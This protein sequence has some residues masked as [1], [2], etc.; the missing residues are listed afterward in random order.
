[1]KV[2]ALFLIMTS[3]SSLQGNSPFW[4]RL[5][6]DL[7]QDLQHIINVTGGIISS[8]LHW[9]SRQW[10]YVGT[11]IAFT[12]GASLADAAI[13]QKAT[14]TRL[15]LLD[16]L[17][18][19]DAYHGSVSSGV[20]GVS[21]YSAGLLLNHPS[22][23]RIG[24]QTIEAFYLS[25]T[26]NLLFKIIIGRRRPYAS[27]SPYEFQPFN[28]TTEYRSMPSG[29]VVTAFAVSTVMAHAYPHSL[30]QTIWYGSALL[31]A[32]ARIY[33]N[34]HWF[35]D[36]IPAAILGYAVG[37]YIVHL[38]DSPQHPQGAITPQR[39]WSLIPG[40]GQLTLILKF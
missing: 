39:R 35:S 21:L 23:R 12:A 11:T 40:N 19:I 29:H 24:L 15:P 3:F 25:G 18:A 30:W 7:Q 38:P 8:P 9:D 2:F 16:H 37:H 13:Q 34:A 31:V 10:G 28:G 33:H 1:M 4:K 36:V 26:I 32:G 17:F 14:T 22:V 27:A 6:R 20:L 5:P